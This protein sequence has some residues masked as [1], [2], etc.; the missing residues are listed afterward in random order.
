MPREIIPNVIQDCTDGLQ[1]FRST[2]SDDSP[3][4]VILQTSFAQLTSDKFDFGMAKITYDMSLQHPTVLILQ[5]TGNTDWQIQFDS[6]SANLLHIVANSQA[7]ATVTVLNNDTDIPIE[8]DHSVSL[9]ASIEG[10]WTYVQD[11]YQGVGIFSYDS[12]STASQFLVQ[13]TIL[14][15]PGIVNPN[16][17]LDLVPAIVEDGSS[18]SCLFGISYRSQIQLN[19]LILIA[20][21]VAVYDNDGDEQTVPKVAFVNIEFPRSLDTTTILVLNSR[22]PQIQ[23]NVTLTGP[24]QPLLEIMAVGDRPTVV[25]TTPDGTDLAVLTEAGGHTDL[26]PPCRFHCNLV[27]MATWARDEYHVP[28]H[29]YDYCVRASRFWFG[30]EPIPTPQPVFTVP[31]TPSP[32]LVVSVTPQPTFAAAT[33]RAP[34]AIATTPQP[35]MAA[36]VETTLAP[37]ETATLPPDTPMPTTMTPS[38][39]CPEIPPTAP[40][41][42]PPA[43]NQQLVRNGDSGACPRCDC[44]NHWFILSIS[45]NVVGATCLFVVW[46]S[47]RYRLVRRRYRRTK[48]EDDPDDIFEDDDLARDM[49]LEL[50]EVPPVT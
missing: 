31:P 23:W 18:S 13:S 38:I 30:T 50:A 49:E 17:Q 40:P 7:Q 8:I 34:V 20:D 44:M 1:T 10:F 6:S 24:P 41:T 9:G 36:T 35:T 32:V 48:K 2:R 26:L 19:P 43:L 16:D 39:H 12:C 25:T 45:M 29:G 15:Y 11:R 4:V 42:I 27:K 28:I 47:S 21:S 14:D 46:F 22:E 37:H 3:W 33:T 5:S